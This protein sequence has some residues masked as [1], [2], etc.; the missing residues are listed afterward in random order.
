[1]LIRKIKSWDLGGTFATKKGF[2]ETPETLA[3]TGANGESRT[4]DLLIT[5]QLLYQLSYGGII[6]CKITIFTSFKLQS[7]SINFAQKCQALH[8]QQPT[9]FALSRPDDQSPAYRD[10]P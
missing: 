8:S 5:N 2:Q 10:H 9:K 7:A 4:P 1:M 6:L 3:I